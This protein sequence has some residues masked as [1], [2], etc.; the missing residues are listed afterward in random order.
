MTIFDYIKSILVTKNKDMDCG[1]EYAPFMVN[2]WLSFLS[3]ASA[4]AI[5]E[6]VN[7]VYLEEKKF[8]YMLLLSLFP[9]MKYQPRINYIKK[10]KA[11]KE[12]E[13]PTIA[14]V[15]NNLERSKR[16]IE[17]L[18]HFSDEQVAIRSKETK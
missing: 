1:T 13:D 18:K 16:E 15:A 6:T 3:P 11:T 4:K 14:L 7:V 12:K 5:N 10:V 2:R 9:R 17:L 8:H